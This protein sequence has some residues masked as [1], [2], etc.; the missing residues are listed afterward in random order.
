MLG[1]IINYY[2]PIYGTSRPFNFFGYFDKYDMDYLS[3]HLKKSKDSNHTFLLSHYPTSTTLFGTSS[4]GETFEELS[5]SISMVF[6]GHLHKLFLNIGAKLF[7]H[8]NSGYL[9]LELG[10]K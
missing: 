7:A 4:T 10:K 5:Q 9:E 1:F 2:S 6:A 3:T 8:Q